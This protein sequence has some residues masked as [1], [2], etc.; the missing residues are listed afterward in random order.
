MLPRLISCFSAFGL[1]IVREIIEGKITRDLKV[2]GVVSLLF[3]GNAVFH[4]EALL[5]LGRGY[6]TR[7]G[8]AG[9]SIDHA[10]RRTHHSERHAQLARSAR[11]APR[12]C[13]PISAHDRT[14]SCVT[15]VVGPH[16]CAPLYE[17]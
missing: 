6:G 13:K 12:P 2:L 7:I 16:G 3:A 1:V 10:D 11:S 17:R 14:G 4:L 8:I 15:S 9:C 5:G